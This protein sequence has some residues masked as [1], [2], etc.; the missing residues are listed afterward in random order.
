MTDRTRYCRIILT[1]LC[2]VLPA[3]DAEA[4]DT[5]VL[6]PSKEFSKLDTFEAVALQDADKL[7]GK[8]DY[9]GAFA[10]Y[11]SYTVDFARGRALPY[12]LLRMGR[13]L[14]RLGKRNTAIRAYQDVVDYF[15]NDVRYAAAALYY[16]GQCH[17]Q[18]G[19]EDKALAVW[20]KMVKD[21]DYVQE[22]R[23]GTALVVLSTAMQKRGDYEEAT[24]FRWR[25]AIAFA[26]SNPEAARQARDQVVYH[27]VVR[28]P[29]REQLLA[30]CKEVGG[31]GWRHRIDKPNDSPTFWRHVL[32]VALSA[33]LS[34][35]K[36]IDVC[37][38]W[39]GQMGDRFADDDALRASWFYLRLAHDKDRAAWVERMYKQFELKPVTIDRVKGWLGHFGRVPDQREAFFEKY[40]L[41]LVDDLADDKKVALMK[42]LRHPFRMHA[43]AAKVMR[44]VRTSDMDDKALRDFAFL[45]A[46]YEG[47][48][49]FLRTV[50]KMKDKLAA[51]R[52][53]FD[54]YFRRSHRNG[55]YQ[56]KAL[57]EIA[58]LSKSPDHA[59]A[60]IWPHAQLMHWQRNYEEAIKLYRSA[61]RQPHSTWAI[62]DCRVAL[63]QYDKAIKLTQELESIGGGIASQACLRA[64]DIY[65]VSGEKKKEVQQLQLV[66]RRYPRSSE[67]STAHQR[68]ENYGV[69]IIGGEAKA[70][71]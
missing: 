1:C 28:S 51:A 64:A 10:A 37:R 56:K 30:F 67:S 19:N 69:K 35:E 46:D 63:K 71:E 22:P 52:T 15:P 24:R 68:L 38:Y 39:D 17:R 25:A 62:I 32:D 66:L 5:E 14:H 57:A 12:V 34:D 31:F 18:N 48:D 47:E 7:F 50:A 42:T 40:G 8:K 3:L 16:I 61:N 44:K 54:F 21:K 33:K 49:A 60:V 65:R 6:Y 13:C 59:Q 20:A 2:L 26:K 36:R 55:D 41:P 58:V 9:R 11:K 23:S 43:Q 29:N 70:G 53:R 45:A 27:Y 4:R